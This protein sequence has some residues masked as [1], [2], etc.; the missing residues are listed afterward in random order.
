M[1]APDGPLDPFLDDPNDPASLL[2]E[3]DP[4]EPLTD[5][6]RIAVQGDLDELAEFK[7]ALAPS[8]VDGIAVECGDCGELHF[9][10]WDLMAANL[11]ALLGEGRTHVHEPAYEPHPDAYVSWDY[12]R[13]YT[14]ATNAAARRH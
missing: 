11:R 12:A 13:G 3:N 4:I 10:G 2:D 1:I 14:D 7:Q 6:E 9:F 5:E 8:G